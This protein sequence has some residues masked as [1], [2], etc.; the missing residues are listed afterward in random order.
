LCDV[1][2]SVFD[3]GKVGNP[4]PQWSR[5]GDDR[6]VKGAQIERISS[7]PVVSVER[8]ANL[9]VRDVIHERP[10]VAQCLNP[11]RV[12]VIPDDSETQ[13]RRLG[14]DRKSDVTL[15]DDDNLGAVVVESPE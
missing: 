6:D 8:H 1:P 7:R 5:Y 11:H 10:A 9:V 2:S 12:R 15:P 14:R 3:E 13:L 4:V